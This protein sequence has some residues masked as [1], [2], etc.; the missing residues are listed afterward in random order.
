M[1]SKLRSLA[2]FLRGL[3]KEGTLGVER[4]FE[5]FCLYSQGGIFQL[6]KYDQAVNEN[7][8]YEFIHSA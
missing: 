8:I 2:A 6:M 5:E 7:K 1:E 4:M 3:R